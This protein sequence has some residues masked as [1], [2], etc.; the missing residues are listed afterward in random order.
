[1]VFYTAAG[2]KDGWVKSQ[3]KLNTGVLNTIFCDFH[4]L[5][6]QCSV[7][8]RSRMFRAAVKTLFSS[9]AESV[10]SLNPELCSSEGTLGWMQVIEMKWIYSK[11]AF[12]LL[13][14]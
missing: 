11:S 10:P 5:P 4:E 1:M 6:V 2:R 7:I 12:L 8:G 9:A 14:L 3:K 13:S